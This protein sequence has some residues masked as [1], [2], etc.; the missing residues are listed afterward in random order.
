I[1]ATDDDK[2][3]LAPI[4]ARIERAG[5]RNVQVRTPKGEADVLADLAG[6]ADCVLIDAP[7]TGI[8]AWRR[9][10]DAKWRMRPGALEIRVREQAEL[11]DRAAGLIKGAG[12]IVYVTCSLLAEEN[13]DQV[14]GFL[15][16][17]PE[18]SA[19]TAAELTRPLGERAVVFARAVVTSAEG[20]LMTPRRTDTDGFFVCVLSRR[21][22]SAPVARVKPPAAA[23]LTVTE[24]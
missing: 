24:W 22:E 3:R 21:G 9:N 15:A 17:H 16:R 6:S 23:E 19:L 12:R 14:R 10:P 7:C 11:L 13:G 5:A 18:F 2:R 1:Y 4:H 20:L 8:G